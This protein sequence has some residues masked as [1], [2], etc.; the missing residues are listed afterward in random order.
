LN[1]I[2]KIGI[3]DLSGKRLDDLIN[4]KF[5]KSIPDIYKLTSEDL[6]KLDKV[7]DK[8]SNKLIESIQKTKKVDLTVFLAS[9]GIAGGAYNKCEK[10]VR[11]GFDSVEKIKNLTPEKL[12]NIE[13]F[14]VKSATDFYQSLSEKFVLIDELLELGFTFTKE[15]TRET[16]ITGKKICITGSLTEK[17]PVFEDK[18]RE[19]GGIVVSSVSKNTDI[20]VTNETDPTSSKFKKALELNIKI[21]TESELLEKLK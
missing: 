12:M 21:I 2:Q 1:F 11:A 8:L 10:V 16:E 6:M 17:R 18:I 9:L 19:G 20:L 15:E 13:S 3:E 5:V 4:A 14:A 7:K